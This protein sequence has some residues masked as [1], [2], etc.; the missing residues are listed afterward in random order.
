M[1]TVGHIGRCT[2][3]IFTFLICNLLGLTVLRILADSHLEKIVELIFGY[4]FL[5]EPVKMHKI[6]IDFCSAC[7]ICCT[8]V[9]EAVSFLIV[10]CSCM[11]VTGIV[12]GATYSLIKVDM[13]QAPRSI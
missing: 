7:E 11:R 5:P 1:A 6:F 8:D 2:P 10:C 4:Q 12:S 13:R 3:A 9:V